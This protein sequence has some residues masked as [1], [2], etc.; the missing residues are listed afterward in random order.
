MIHLAQFGAQ[1]LEVCSWQSLGHKK[2]RD[3]TVEPQR[4]CIRCWSLG[5][6]KITEALIHT[7][8]LNQSHQGSVSALP[9]GSS[10]TST[11]PWC[12]PSCTLINL[13]CQGHGDAG[14]QKITP[15]GEPSSSQKLMVAHV[16][17]SAWTSLFRGYI[18]MYC[19]VF[20]SGSPKE[21]QESLLRSRIHQSRWSAV[22]KDYS[23]LAEPGF[24]I[25]G[26]HS[27]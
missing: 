23:R 19:S 12:V 9:V 22:L 18:H 26:H 4:G 16:R 6:R 21:E 10:G 17:M 3:T 1:G 5:K 27:V 13:G 2:K 20:L 7:V 15:W 14:W 24:G 11:G 8:E 25:Q